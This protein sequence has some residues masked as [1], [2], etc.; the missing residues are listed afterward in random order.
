VLT[1]REF[2]FQDLLNISLVSKSFW[3]FAQTDELWKEITLNHFWD[4]NTKLGRFTFQGIV[5]YFVVILFIYL[6]IR[7]FI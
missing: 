1:N 2:D 6:F 4:E 5:L 7:L 3:I